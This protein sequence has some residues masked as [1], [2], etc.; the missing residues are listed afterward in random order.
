MTMKFTFASDVDG[1][2][3]GTKDIADRFDEVSDTLVDLARRGED[4]GDQLADSLGDSGQAA[5]KLEAKLKDA[6]D[7][8]QDLA[9]GEKAADALGDGMKDAGKD[10]ERFEDKA[11]GAFKS[12]GDSA[13]KSGDV[14]GSA[15]KQGTKEAEGGLEDFRDE[16]NSTAKETA[17]SFDGS[18]DSI[19]GMAQEVAAN[20]FAGFGPA[21]AVA[22]L[23]AAAGIGIAITQMQAGAEAANKMNE[24]AVDLAGQIVEAGGDIRDVD[25]GAI[26]S[27]WGREVIEDNWIT[28]WANEAST[29]FQETA[30][31]AQDANR[32]VA[33]SVR[34]AAGSADDSR[35]F[36][37]DTAETWQRLTRR[38]QEG[39]TTT[40]DGLPVQDEAARAAQKERDAL[41][42]L[43]GQAEENIKT[44]EAAVDIA[45]I[46]TAATGDNTAAIE[47]NIQALE[48]KAAAMADAA[49]VA[50]D[51][52]TAEIQYADTMAQGAKDIAAN[53]K[54]LELNTA[55][56]RANQQTLVDMAKSANELRDAQV[57]AG[58]STADITAKQ[59]QARTAF[60]NAAVAAGMGKTEAGKLA[61]QYGLIPG[62]VDTYVKAHNVQK[63]KDEIDGVAEPRTVPIHLTRGSESISSW[64]QG[65]S[66]RTIPVNMAVRGGR[67]VD[68]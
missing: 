39:T 11:K 30:K 33:E 15:M 5:D 36:L 20:A 31:D 67:A 22:G 46:E 41:S 64:I 50:M 2:V 51:A 26:V 8:A 45:E 19:A 58:G 16:A 6:L 38:I 1:V 44:K 7:A 42:D 62:N 35:K 9:K 3:R 37:D 27:A 34:A 13:R 68:D 23:A 18:F 61:T 25:L 60:I 32:D 55:T 57:A 24:A 65:L 47:A 63:T 17:A 4:S 54:G 52:T 14:V 28:P 29:K 48:D 49:G 12:L 53:G 10:V 40:M 43:R 21:G 56:G 59:N 66:G